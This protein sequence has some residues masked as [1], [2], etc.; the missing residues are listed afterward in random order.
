MNLA[1]CKVLLKYL[2]DLELYN[3]SLHC[4]F[5]FEVLNFGFVK[6]ISSQLMNTAH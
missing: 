3:T 5:K 4:H 2:K 1:Y 6:Q